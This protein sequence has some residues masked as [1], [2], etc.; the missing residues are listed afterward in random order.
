MT[1]FP[2]PRFVGIETDAMELEIPYFDEL[3]FRNA[4]RDGAQGGTCESMNEQ[5]F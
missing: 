1:Q 2:G 5:G 4:A 3:S